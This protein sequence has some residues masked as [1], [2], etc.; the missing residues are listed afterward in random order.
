MNRITALHANLLF[1]ILLVFG[2]LTIWGLV[3]AAR[4]RPPG[5]LYLSALRIGELLLIAQALLGV[6][7][8]AGGLRPAR[9]ELHVVYAVVAVVTLP[10]AQR[11]VRDRTPR[12]QMLT[13]ALACLF[14]CAIVLRGVETGRAAPL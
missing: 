11:Y 1:T 6:A 5:A 7:L 12:Q 13:Y 2:A 9:P 4:S 14:L 10:A 8:L 3:E